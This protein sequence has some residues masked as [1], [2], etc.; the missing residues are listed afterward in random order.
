MTGHSSRHYLPTAARLLGMR[1]EDRN[2]LGRW[3]AATT[4]QA[5]RRGSM[6][7][8]YPA[9]EAEPARVRQVVLYA[10]TEIDKKVE[11]AGG[12]EAISASHAQPWDALEGK[13]VPDLERDLASDSSSDEE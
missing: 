11:S 2:E 12:P 9:K 8:L 13:N 3:A 4:D 6:P 10:V 5:A 7:N 1:I